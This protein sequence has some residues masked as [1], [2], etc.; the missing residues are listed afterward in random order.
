MMTHMYYLGSS[1][2]LSVPSSFYFEG[3]SSPSPILT[4][5]SFFIII[6]IIIT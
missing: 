4:T 6:I 2:I 5:L 1:S 3:P